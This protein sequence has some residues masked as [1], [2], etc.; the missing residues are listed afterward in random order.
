VL[1]FDDAALR[2][3]YENMLPEA[4]AQV[5]A[6]Y[7]ARHPNRVPGSNRWNADIERF[8]AQTAERMT[9]TEVGERVAQS[10]NSVGRVILSG[11][12][13]TLCAGRPG[14]F[15][16][17]G[18]ADNLRIQGGAA[19]LLDIIRTNG[20]PAEQGVVEAAEQLAKQGR[21]LG[22]VD[23]VVSVGGRVLIIA[24]AAADVWHVNSADDR[25][26]A[27]AEV[28]GGWAGAAAGVAAHNAATGPSN[29]A[30]PWAWVGNVVAGGV[31]Y[32]A[33][34]TAAG[35]IYD[36]FVDPDPLEIRIE[37]PNSTLMTGHCS[38]VPSAS[39]APLR[40]ISLLSQ[41]RR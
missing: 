16:L 18:A 1:E 24:G 4:R 22:A 8:T 13:D 27:T 14:H 21:I 35:E 5:E 36:L 6:Q 33:G 2:E 15:I 41:P 12:D 20:V 40:A 7:A 3:I 39:G 30:G 37:R 34:S 25:L 31:G 28:A 19:T 23:D 29:A 11:A 32:F 10:E 9:W 26:R 38:G 17:S